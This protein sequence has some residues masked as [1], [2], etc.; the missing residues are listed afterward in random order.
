MDD[1]SLAL[2]HTIVTLSLPFLV[3]VSKKLS[4]A[5]VIVCV[6]ESFG[7]FVAFVYEVK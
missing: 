7:L 6:F 5:A 2:S 3:R 4:I 1:N